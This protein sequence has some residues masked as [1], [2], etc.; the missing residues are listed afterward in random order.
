MLYLWCMYVL[1]KCVCDYVRLF[2]CLCVCVYVLFLQG[3]ITKPFSI[4]QSQISQ[5]SARCSIAKTAYTTRASTSFAPSTN[6]I[7]APSSRCSSQHQASITRFRS[8]IHQ[9]YFIWP[10]AI[11]QWSTSSIRFRVPQDG[12]DFWY[13]L[14]NCVWCWRNFKQ[15]KF[16]THGTR[17]CWSKTTR[18]RFSRSSS[19][20]S[21]S[22]FGW[23]RT[24]SRKVTIKSWSFEKKQSKTNIVNLEQQQQQYQQHCHQHQCSMWEG[25]GLQRKGLQ[26]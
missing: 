8:W 20:N 12:F 17:F 19:R 14:W 1:S 16:R 25:A 9:L 18:T 11:V 6:C 2:V 15:P 3:V 26:M 5:N 10:E 22:R 7:C 23:S 13:G 4:N 24:S 21:S